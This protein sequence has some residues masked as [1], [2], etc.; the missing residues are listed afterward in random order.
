MCGTNQGRQ[1]ILAKRLKLAIN[2]M[3]SARNISTS[4]DYIPDG[5]LFSL[6]VGGSVVLG[7]G[8]FPLDLY[9]V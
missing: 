1:M 8:Q 4:R 9:C 5:D 3:K 6:S 2:P 7:L